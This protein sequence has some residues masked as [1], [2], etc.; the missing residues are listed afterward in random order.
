MDSL[1][2]ICARHDDT[3]ISIAASLAYTHHQ[4]DTTQ[5]DQA[6]AQQYDLHQKA[7]SVLSLTPEE[8]PEAQMSS[9]N[10][11]PVVS[12]T[13]R[14]ASAISSSEPKQAGL[15]GT[16]V[17]SRHS[18][19]GCSAEPG[20]SPNRQWM[21]SDS[22]RAG[23]YEHAVQDL[24]ARAGPGAVCVLSGAAAH[25]AVAAAGCYNVQQVVCLQVKH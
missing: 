25:L 4:T 6:K 13:R 2:Q 5:A 3:S 22:S 16:G 15:T 8:H 24:L 21:L 10:C 14:G 20:A 7:H 17:A 11:Q 9:E 19:R 23:H 1:I 18:H 12:D